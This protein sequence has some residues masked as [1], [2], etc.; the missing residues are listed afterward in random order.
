MIIQ[1]IEFKD[2]RP[3]HGFQKI[4]L[5]EDLEKNI[6]FI[7]AENGSGKTTLLE[8]IKWCL[9][10]TINLP[11]KDEFLN[12][13]TAAQTGLNEEVSVHVKVTFKDEESIYTA[14]RVI[15]II[16]RGE[17]NFVKKGSAVLTL[18]KK[19]KNGI[20]KKIISAP[21]SEIQKII[22]KE[23]NFFFDGERLSNFDNK[24]TL[25]KSIEGILGVETSNN[26][27]KHLKLVKKSLN[28]ELIELEKKI[29]NIGSVSLKEKIELANSTIEKNK[30]EINRIE[31]EILKANNIL[32]DKEEKQLSIKDIEDFARQ[33]K[34]KEIKLEEIKIK[35]KEQYEKIRLHYSKDSYLG[36]INKLIEDASKILLEKKKKKEVPSK[37]SE[38]LINE[39]IE[40]NRCICGT[41]I[42]LDSPEYLTLQ[43]LKKTSSSDKMINAFDSALKL[44]ESEKIKRTNFYDNL[45]SY[46]EILGRYLYEEDNLNKEISELDKKIDK[47]QNEEGKLLKQSIDQ[48]KR[49]ISDYNQ[50][51]G[52]LKKEIEEKTKKIIEFKKNLTVIETT[53]KETTLLNKRINFS[54]KLIK[55]LETILKKKK[56]TI[57]KELIKKIREIYS[58]TT[59]KGYKIQ[60]NDDFLISIIDPENGKNIAVSTG[61]QKIATLCFIGALAYVSR[62]IHN[63]KSSI[64]NGKIFPIILDSPFGDLDDEHRLKLVKILPSLADQIVLLTSSSQATQEMKAELHPSIGFF[65]TLYNNKNLDKTQ[66]YEVTDIYKRENG[67][68][69]K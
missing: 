11:N 59:R 15:E 43:N 5:S 42:K 45:N 4:K 6:T 40:N 9:Y 26:A 36:P 16:K 50:K 57:K 46:F 21:E 18:E 52:G 68:W 38:F 44:T 49:D 17:N 56:E 35:I 61:E 66:K 54:E 65:Y 48:L 29:G 39:L 3:F 25:K 67:K 51:I 27:I 53:N 23:M 69:V 30:N 10:G 7:N 64:E 12:K 37:V 33:K 31:V 19:D 13:K 55:N 22:P 63:R 58:R 8:G 28:E 24:S 32:K 34:N 47:N 1:E 2:F 62:E 20:N 41:E 14:A 60:L